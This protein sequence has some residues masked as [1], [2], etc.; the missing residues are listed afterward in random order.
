MTM[1]PIRNLFRTLSSLNC[2]VALACASCIGQSAPTPSSRDSALARA[3]DGALDVPALRMGF[4]G[5]LIQSLRDGSTLYAR[6]PDQVFLPAS[7]NKLLTSAAA[8][9]ILGQR[10]TYHTRLL[11]TGT[12]D[13]T[14]ALHGDLVLQGSGDPILTPDDLQDLARQAG[15]NGIHRVLGELCYDD[16]LFDAQRLGDGWT[17]DD[18]PYAYSAQISA[19]NLNE[20]VVDLFVSPGSTVG[21]PVHV[22]VKPTDRCTTVN[23]NG[24]TTSVGSPSTLAFDRIEG[25]NTILVRGTLPFNTAASDTPTASLTVD[26]PARFAVTVL[27]ADLQTG[28]VVLEHI[29]PEHATTPMG[30]VVVADHASPGLPEILKRLNKPSDNLIAECLLKT[31]GATRSRIGAGGYEGTGPTAA[32]AYFQTIGLDL[33][34]LHQVDGSGLSRGNYV[35]P[36]N[37]VRLLAAMR[38]AP[39]FTAFYDSL[40]IAAVDGTLAHRM[41]GTLAAGNCRAKTGTMSH[42]SALSGYVTTRDGE[43]LAFSIL[44]NN[45]LAP[46]AVCTA[47]QDRIVTLLASYARPPAA[48][49]VR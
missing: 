36:H 33:N 45:H 30:A 24:T 17:W 10:F 11:R 43:P 8:I 4:Q 19:L 14:G 40:P 42:V 29:L 47:V 2:L 1:D 18:E 35:S 32:R 28:G 34:T 21:A 41:R 23:N 37:L 6:N 38:H 49:H 31:I 15:A 25:S 13:A 27:E 20:N 46:T 39:D 12:V 3:I 5:I 7:N 22:I 48:I 16:S 26:D 44:M 9:A